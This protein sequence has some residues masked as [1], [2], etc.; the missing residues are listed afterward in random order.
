MKLPQKILCVVDPTVETHPVIKR[1]RWLA[2]RTGAHLELRVCFYDQRL[3]GGLAFDSAA[4]EEARTE[5]IAEQQRALDGI[6]E[7]LSQEGLTASASAVWDHP[8]HEAIVRSATS[9]GADIVLKDT[10]RHDGF[11][12]RTLSNTDWSLIRTCPV[13][14]WL[15]KPNTKMSSLNVIAAVD[16]NHEHDKP[17]ELD[18]LIVELG[19]AMTQ[20]EGETLHAF[21]AV[22]TLSTLARTSPTTMEPTF[23]FGDEMVER[24]LE[25]HRRTFDDLVAREGITQECT[26]FFE[27]NMH[28]VLPNLVANLDAEL[29]VLGA[30]AR[31]RLKRLFIGSSAERT[32]DRVSCDLLVVHPNRSKSPVPLDNAVDP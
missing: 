9:L 10:H 19:R 25:V 4:L 32:L 28:E 20:G 6:V 11:D 8:L 5:V 27:G 30:V 23:R 16:P 13:P 1:A 3:S 21:H 12:I 24:M 15:V 18:S 22:N 14:L 7:K 26:H 31:T 17:A 2:E 29:V